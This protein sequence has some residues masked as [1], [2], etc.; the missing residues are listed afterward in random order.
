MVIGITGT[1]GSGKTAAAEMLKEK[2][3]CY[4][5]EAD[6]VQKELS[7]KGHEYYNR[8]VAVFGEAILDE[9]RE[10]IRPKLAKIVYSDYNKREVLNDLTNIYVVD[11]VKAQ[12]G[13]LPEGSTVIIDV[14]RLVEC[15]LGKMCDVIISVLADRE[16]KLGRIC[17]RDNIDRKTAENRLNI[18]QNDQ[19]YIDNSNYIIKNN[20]DDLEEKIDVILNSV[21]I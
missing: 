20:D 4:L 1:S 10:I 5:I 18:Q 14:P 16:I 17:K 21:R 6:D 9:N 13:K 8:I 12:I 7:K 2:L 3:K 15:G 11:E 19:F